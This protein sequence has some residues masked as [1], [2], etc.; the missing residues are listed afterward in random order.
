MKLFIDIECNI[1]K[2]RNKFFKYS[3]KTDSC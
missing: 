3:Q 1:K 2:E